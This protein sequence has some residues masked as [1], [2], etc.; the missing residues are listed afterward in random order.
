MIVHRS[1]RRATYIYQQPI[2]LFL[3]PL[4]RKKIGN[5]QTGA[6]ASCINTPVRDKK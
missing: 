3:N 6:H 2:L 5:E 1:A 4:Y